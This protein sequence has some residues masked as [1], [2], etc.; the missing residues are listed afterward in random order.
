MHLGSARKVKRGSLKVS[1]HFVTQVTCVG[2]HSE[3]YGASPSYNGHV[4]SKVSACSNPCYFPEC[5]YSSISASSDLL[6]IQ[7][8]CLRTASP[9]LPLLTA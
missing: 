5:H 4:R 2:S 9:V 1:F 8:L 3:S 6:E 7:W